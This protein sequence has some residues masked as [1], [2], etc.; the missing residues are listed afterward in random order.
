VLQSTKLKGIGDLK[1]GLTS[2][3]EIQNL[4]FAHWVLF[5]V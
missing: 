2:N 5:L 4:E 3:I 1:I